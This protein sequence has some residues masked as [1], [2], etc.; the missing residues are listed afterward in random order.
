ME[1]VVGRGGRRKIQHQI[2]STKFSKK[3]ST[4]FTQ[5]IKLPLLDLRK[6]SYHVVKMKK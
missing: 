5:N 6:F 3:R 2:F 1:E 4:T